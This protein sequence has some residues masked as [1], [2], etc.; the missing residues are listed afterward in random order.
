[1]AVWRTRAYETFGFSA[2]D[3]SYSHGKTELFADLVVMAAR[4]DDSADSDIL[5][6]IADYVCWAASQTADGLQS[7]VDLA[8]FL[9]VIRD[10]KLT[11]LMRGRIPIDLFDAKV[12]LLTEHTDESPA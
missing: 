11:A 3:Y 10:D 5:D 8:F 1:M 12:A 6:H 9:P 4:A 2:G 7:A